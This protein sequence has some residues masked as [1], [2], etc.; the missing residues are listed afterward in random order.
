[1]IFEKAVVIPDGLYA[2]MH[3]FCRN[4]RHGTAAHCT[5]ATSDPRLLAR[6]NANGQRL[7]CVTIRL[8]EI[9]ITDEDVGFRLRQLPLG[10]RVKGDAFASHAFVSRV[11]LSRS[12]LALVSRVR[13]SRARRA[14]ANRRLRCAI[15]RNISYMFINVRIISDNVP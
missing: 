5:H 13:R 9:V 14:C 12:S 8:P 4:F 3:K 11:R 2:L 10:E 6:A 1:M 7:I 15:N